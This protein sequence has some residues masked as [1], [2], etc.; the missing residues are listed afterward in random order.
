MSAKDPKAGR[1]GKRGLA[2]LGPALG[3]EA[4][5]FAM[6]LR[7]LLALSGATL[8]DAAEATGKDTSTVSRYCGGERLPE[9]AWLRDFLAWVDQQGELSDGADRQ[10]RELLW[11]AARIKGPLVNRQFQLDRA[12]EELAR[13]REQAAA[14]L[15]QLR[16]ELEAERQRSHLLEDQLRSE[17]AAS[18]RR[19]EEL[20][21][22]IRQSEAVLRLLQHDE[23]RM[24]D[25]IRET[26][27]ELTSWSGG[28][29]EYSSSEFTQLASASANE[30]VAH[31]IELGQEGEAARVQEL[32][33]EAAKR[34]TSRESL[35][36]RNE[37]RETGRHDEGSA[38]CDLIGL[39]RS[40]EATATLVAAWRD[41]SNQDPEGQLTPFTLSADLHSI[42]AAARGRPLPDLQQ[43]C[44]ALV[45]NRQNE[46]VVEILGKSGDVSLAPEVEGVKRLVAAWLA[47]CSSQVDSI[48]YR[49]SHNQLE[50]IELDLRS[51]EA[52][53]EF[54]NNAL[55]EIRERAQ[56]ARRTT[57]K[58][59]MKGWVRRN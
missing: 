3:P 18:Q 47:G 2:P 52:Y 24:A 9:L 58:G 23:E 26:A 21:D 45:Q 41:P 7:E 51:V 6:Y 32:L 22:Q 53:R 38:Y 10:G 19:I 50:F 30:I 59:R 17:R 15:A 56:G 36:L 44:Q 13:Q 31:V 27:D 46:A 42:L 57:I 11:A 8:T 25:M 40:A 28:L 48:L 37:L 29:A 14:A 20:E 39:Y 34:R 1:N 55:D 5:A 16:E 35:A 33:K 43:L 49:A 54:P 12:A 4:T